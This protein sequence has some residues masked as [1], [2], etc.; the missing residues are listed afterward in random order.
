MERPHFDPVTRR[1]RPKKHCCRCARTAQAPAPSRP[2]DRKEL[3]GRIR[4][5]ARAELEIRAFRLPLYRQ[6]QVFAHRKSVMRAPCCSKSA[7][8][9]I[10]WTLA[11]ISNCNTKRRLTA[12]PQCA[13]SL[14]GYE[15][16]PPAASFTPIRTYRGIQHRSRRQADNCCKASCRESH[17]FGLDTRLRV[18]SLILW[19]VW[20]GY[21]SSISKALRYG[22]ATANLSRRHIREAA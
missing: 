21:A 18:A 9:P 20:H 13:A 11:I 17:S 14:V 22:L 4:V 7:S 3:C 10:A 19:R 5:G 15:T 12:H 1:I 2:I 16:D 6:C 8:T